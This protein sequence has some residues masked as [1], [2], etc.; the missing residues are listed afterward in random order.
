MKNKSKQEAKTDLEKIVDHLYIIQSGILRDIV[1]SYDPSLDRYMHREKLEVIN[2]A[3]KI[4]TFH[5]PKKEKG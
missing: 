2:M 4:V 1:N 5:M 3:I